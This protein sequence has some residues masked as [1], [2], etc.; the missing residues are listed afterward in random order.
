[1]IVEVCCIR[2]ALYKTLASTEEC[3][4]DCGYQVV[5]GIVTGNRGQIMIINNDFSHFPR[6]LNGAWVFLLWNRV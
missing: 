4:L 3:T 1:M 6:P 5:S 2:F